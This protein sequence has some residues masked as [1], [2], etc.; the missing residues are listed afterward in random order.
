M[1]DVH[2]GYRAYNR[3]T[4]QG[5]N[6]RE[7]DVF[8]AFS[9]AMD[10][11]AT[12]DVDLIVIAGDLFHVVR[13]SN[14]TIGESFKKFLELRQKTDAPI[15]IIGGNHDSP[16]SR[17]TGC[18]LDLFANIPNVWVVHGTYEQ[19]KLKESDTS[20]FCL[21]HRALGEINNLKIEPDADS[22][23]NV[24]VAH[25][26]VEGTMRNFLDTVEIS[27]A[28]LLSDK[29]DYIALGHYHAY[30]K[31]ADNAYYSGSLEHTGPY[32]WLKPDY[33]RGFIEYDTETR[34]VVK[35]HE[36]STRELVDM[37]AIDA[38]NKSG[39][40][41]NKM[42]E[43]RIQG[44]RGGHEDKIIRLVIENLTR[45]VQNDL[46]F[47]FVRQVRSEALH[48]DLQM[49]PPGKAAK[50][51]TDTES[52][53]LKSIEEEWDDFAKD[54]ELEKA[55]DRDRFITVGKEYIEGTGA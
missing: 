55:I 41:V 20:V 1:S 30:E 4:S 38:E 26:T 36:V 28:D 52:G 12:L 3:V 22:K 25:G 13:P 2:L 47:T 14:V 46:D 5:I 24:L 17:D 32:L 54:Y 33:A 39:E 43:N 42:I 19:I 53:V 45:S 9:Q 50:R 48:F 8:K 27:R 10:K 34:K 35:F 49:R 40:E 37:G 16:R 15:I 51:A 31:K 18:I 29:W 23:H 44:I 6:R 21:P 11:I 7:A